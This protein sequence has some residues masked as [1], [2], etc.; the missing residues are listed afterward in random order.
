VSAAI[1]S[2]GTP[3]AGRAAWTIGWALGA[4]PALL[5][6]ADGA[7]KLA[8]PAP[9]VEATVRLGFPGSALT[10]IGIA[11]LGATAL[12]L[13]PATAVPGAILLTGYLG[14]AIATH[15]RVDA[16][17]FPIL[18][19]ALLA[20][21]LWGGLWLREPRLRRLVRCAQDPLRS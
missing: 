21:L 8:Q 12:H 13:L 3:A 18:F 6:L 9:V 15:V 14:G 19:P 10:G 5:L 20:A 1:S 11:L 16:H 7:L 4:L 17:P 2:E